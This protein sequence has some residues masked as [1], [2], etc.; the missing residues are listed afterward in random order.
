MT[1]LNWLSQQMDTHGPCYALENR[2]MGML[3]YCAWLN[4]KRKGER[5]TY[6]NYQEFQI[7]KRLLEVM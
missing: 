5:P 6:L 3:E 4:V 7:S 2:R 1:Y